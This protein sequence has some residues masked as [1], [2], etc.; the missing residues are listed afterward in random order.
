MVNRFIIDMMQNHFR[1][2][3]N[4]IKINTK[5][6]QKKVHFKAIKFDGLPMGLKSAMVHKNYFWIKAV[7]INGQTIEVQQQLEANTYILGFLTD[8]I[9]NLER[10]RLAQLLIEDGVGYLS[11][12]NESIPV[13]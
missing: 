4:I 9:N 11:L 6:E 12:R 8:N 2:P 10:Y 5:S 7:K 1:E 3:T 13:E